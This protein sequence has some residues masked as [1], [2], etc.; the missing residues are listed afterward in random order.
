MT[1]CKR[2]NNNTDT[3]I[4]SFFTTDEICPRCKTHERLIIT[5]IDAKGIDYKSYEKCGYLPNT[6]DL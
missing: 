1:T 5:V 6:E 3:L 4:E 2:C